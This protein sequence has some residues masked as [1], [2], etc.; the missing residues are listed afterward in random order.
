MNAKD[1]RTVRLEIDTADL[2]QRLAEPFE[3][4]LAGCAACTEFRTE[5]AQLRE[6][7]GSLKPV[8]APP[9]FDMRLRARMARERE[10]R[11][12]QPFIFRFAMTTPAIAIVAILVAA[13]ASIVWLNQRN[14]TLRNDT[15]V[16][17]Q[18]NDKASSATAPTPN[19]A[20]NQPTIATVKPQEAA[21][22]QTPRN[23]VKSLPS[24]S[25]PPRVSDF[26]NNAAPSFKQTPDRAGE[27]WLSAPSKPMVV[28]VRDANGAT[29]KIL[30][31]PISFG[32]QRLDTRTPV[33]MSNGKD[34]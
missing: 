5:R 21:K 16:V 3:M 29:R 26:S 18:G 11:A 12:R 20:G 27:V 1:C 8:A 15:A 31:P 6:L 32:S 14:Q 34:W 10:N 28:S 25:A 33:S 4:H 7:V 23:A 30:L 2:G 22:P 9:D 17:T 24:A 13:V 19:N